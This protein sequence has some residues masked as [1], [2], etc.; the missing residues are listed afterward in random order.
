MYGYSSCLYKHV[1]DYMTFEL[2]EYAL[3]VME[4]AFALLDAI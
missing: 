2:L 3:V 4:V 1:V